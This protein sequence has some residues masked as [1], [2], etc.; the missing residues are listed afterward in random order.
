LKVPHIVELLEFNK[1]GSRVEKAL[2]NSNFDE[3]IDAVKAEKKIWFKL[4]EQALE[5]DELIK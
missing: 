2:L 4:S 1:P 3:L 5:A